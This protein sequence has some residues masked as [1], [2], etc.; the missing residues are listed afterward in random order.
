MGS[1]QARD[2]RSIRLPEYDYTQPGAYTITICT[3]SRAPL[4]GQIVD[5]AMWLNRAGEVVH[6]CWR[7]IPDHNHPAEL[8][9]FV[10]M[11]NH[12]HGIIVLGQHPRGG[13]TAC[14]ALTEGFGA[15]VRA[16]LPTIVRSFKSAATRRVNQLRGTP[17]GRV[18]QRGYCER[19]IRNARELS[20]VRRYV[21]ENPLKWEL[22]PE[23]PANANNKGGR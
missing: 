16:S 13:D 4:F 5:G 3:Q 9:A 19:V 1:N 17:G 11:P 20:A 12:L 6:E 18:W 21:V 2:R 10:V 22:D 14:R 7:E 15:P 23:N 8:D